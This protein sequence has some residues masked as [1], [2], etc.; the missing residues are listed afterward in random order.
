MAFQYAS[1]GGPGGFAYDAGD[2]SGVTDTMVR[3]GADVLST[4][5]LASSGSDLYAMIDETS[6]SDSDYAYRDLAGTEPFIFELYRN[7]VPY[8]LPAGTHTIRMRP[9][10]SSGTGQIRLLLLDAGG[11]TVG[12]GAW[13]AVSDAWATVTHTITTNDVATQGRIEAQA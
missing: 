2:W 9:S 12:T 4:G 8:S 11:A 6:A 13:Q 1:S 7:G 3:P 10:V 5:W